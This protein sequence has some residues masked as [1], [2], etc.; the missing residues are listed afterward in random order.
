MHYPQKTETEAENQKKHQ[1]QV[2]DEKK[3]HLENQQMCYMTITSPPANASNIQNL[4]NRS[5]KNVVEKHLPKRCTAALLDDIRIGD[6]I[7][8]ADGVKGIITDIYIGKKNSEKHYYLGLKHGV[9]L[10]YII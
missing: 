3:L 7:I 10:L 4:S 9:T 2:K 8:N 1:P 5:R 6:R